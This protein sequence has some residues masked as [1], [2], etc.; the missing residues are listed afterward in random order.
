MKK[1]KDTFI[2]MVVSLF[3]ITIIAGFSLGFVNELTVGP[4]EKGKIERKVNALKQ[5]LPEFDNN[6][7]D[8]IQL[9]KSEFAKDSVEV[10]PAF[11]N[12]EFVGAAI[13]GSTEKG[14]SGL[15]K[16]MVG[17][18][19]DGNIKNIAVLEQK[20]TPG[21]GTKMKDE[22]YLAQY[23]EKNP[24]TFNLKVTKDGGEVDALTGATITSRAFGEAVQMAY[25]EFIK[26]NDALKELKN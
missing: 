5:V 15:I 17:F 7:V 10:Y 2:N 21:L 1:K 22:K 13:I 25:D 20:E 16:I 9:V 3:A 24:S 18:T 14:F 26:N 23:R 12:N 6:P 19:P 4:I 8:E 11:K